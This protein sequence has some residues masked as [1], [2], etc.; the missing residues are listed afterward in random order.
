MDFI[1][2]DINDY[3]ER[4]TK[5]ESEVLQ[6]LNRHTNV[7]ILRPRM[8]SGHLQGKLLSMFS[9]MVK[10]NRVLEI[11][12]YTG[13]S[14]ICLAKGIPKG[15]ELITIDCNEELEELANDYFDKAGYKSIIKMVT[16][17]ASGIIPTLTGEFDLV[18]IDADKESYLDYYNQVFDLVKVGGYIIVDNVLWSGKVVRKV[19]EGERETKSIIAFNAFVQQDERVENILLPF[20]DGLMILQKK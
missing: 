18:F 13:Y 8:L 19:K 2:D 11:G 12:T 5:K 4:H 9:G 16:G 14:A 7:N 20:R 17:D 10:P 6:E 1:P 15:G 3:C